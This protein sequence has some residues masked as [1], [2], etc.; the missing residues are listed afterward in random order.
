MACATPDAPRRREDCL[1]VWGAVSA[2]PIELWLEPERHPDGHLA[3]YA[4]PGAR[5]SVLEGGREIYV[6]A[7][8]STEF[9]TRPGGTVREMIELLFGAFEDRRVLF[10]DVRS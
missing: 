5:F 4:W 3:L 1:S 10:R 6:E 8:I 7:E 9:P 2:R